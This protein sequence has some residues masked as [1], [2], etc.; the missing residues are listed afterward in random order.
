MV[1]EFPKNIAS[2]SRSNTYGLWV[3]YCFPK[4]N[5]KLRS[6][7]EIIITKQPMGI[8]LPTRIPP[9]ITILCKTERL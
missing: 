3:N 2:K 5:K 4:L 6:L 8:Q 9:V 7:T 1:L